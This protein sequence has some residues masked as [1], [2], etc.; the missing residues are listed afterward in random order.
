MLDVIECPESGPLFESVLRLSK[1]ARATV[2]FM[3]DSAFR[4]RA[5]RGTLLLAM[6]RDLVVGYLVYDLPRDEVRI[7]QLV[8]DPAARGTGAARLLVDEVANRHSGRRGIVLECRR[9]FPANAMWPKL[10]FVPEA[11]RPGR[12]SQGRRLTILVQKLWASDC[13][14]YC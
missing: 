10:Q 9:D 8:T 7:R 12:G 6:S 5:V 14:L 3:P 2:G 13:I 1:L 11:E 4:D